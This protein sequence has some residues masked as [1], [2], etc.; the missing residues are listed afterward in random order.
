MLVLYDG[1]CGFCD[2]SVQWIL[3]HDA[4]GTFRFAP[5]QGETAREVKARH[6]EMPEDL[7][8]IVLVDGEH[9]SWRSEAIFR[10]CARLDGAWKVLAWLR[11]LP[12]ALTDLGY[13]IFASHRYRWFGRV[14]S[15]RVPAPGQ[16]ARFLP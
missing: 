13:R 5:L 8:S 12:R 9:V 16:R 6:P 7:D 11:W 15:C 3:R 14:D 4:A 2:T 10:I 1:T